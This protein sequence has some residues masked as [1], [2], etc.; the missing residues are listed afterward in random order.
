MDENNDGDG[1]RPELCAAYRETI[2]NQIGGLKKDIEKVDS[3]TWFI[4]AGIIVSIFIGILSLAMTIAT[5][6]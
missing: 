1:V 3:R 2:V 5:R 4:L 6:G